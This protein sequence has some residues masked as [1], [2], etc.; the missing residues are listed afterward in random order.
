MR[1]LLCDFTLRILFCEGA[2]LALPQGDTVPLTPVD[3][4]RFARKM[5]K[6][7]ENLVS[8]AKVIH[9]ILD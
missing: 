7:F 3:F 9:E 2:A 8:C 6:D 5:V 1:F 4:A